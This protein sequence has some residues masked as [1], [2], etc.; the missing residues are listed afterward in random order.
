M[1]YDLPSSAALAYLGDAVFETLVRERLVKSG[2]S[3]SGALNEASL[4]YVRAS[5]QSDAIERILPL[6]SEEENDIFMRGRNSHAGAVPKHTSAAQY[7]RATGFEALF[8]AL[9]YLGR[10]E[11]LT[12]LFASAFPEETDGIGDRQNEAK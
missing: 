4:K 1:A 5:C 12:E 3:L 7:R 9:Y 6:L 8:G 2:L 10:T 11:R